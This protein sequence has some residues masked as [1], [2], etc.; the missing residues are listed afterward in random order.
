MKFLWENFED[1]D[2]VLDVFNLLS[3]IWK[4]EETTVRCVN[5][6]YKFNFKK[7]NFIN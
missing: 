4:R 7:A 6:N 3:E 2:Y 5:F 1:V